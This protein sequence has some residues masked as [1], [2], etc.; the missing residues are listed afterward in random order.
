MCSASWRA[1]RTMD[2]KFT[3]S[4]DSAFCKCPTVSSR[5]TVIFWVRSPAA[6]RLAHL[7][8]CCI[9]DTNTECM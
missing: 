2:S 6:M 8:I 9:G 4:C 3:F 5:D 7:S 1:S